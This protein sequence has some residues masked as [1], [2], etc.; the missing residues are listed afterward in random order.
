MLHKV[1]YVFYSKIL[2]KKLSECDKLKSALKEMD[3]K[4]TISSEETAGEEGSDLT[5]TRWKCIIEGDNED[6][7]VWTFEKLLKME[8]EGGHRA[9]HI[10]IIHLHALLIL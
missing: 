1:T 10:I 2:A 9:I 4:I 3:V 6:N 8:E 5:E 7:V